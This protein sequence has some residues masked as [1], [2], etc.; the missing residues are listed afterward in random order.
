ENEQLAF[1]VSASHQE[2]EKVKAK[3]EVHIAELENQIQELENRPIET[4]HSE[5][6]KQEIERLT[7]QNEA[8]EEQCTE[9]EQKIYAYESQE[10]TQLEKSPEY[11]NL[12]K[13]MHNNSHEWAEKYDALQEKSWQEMNELKRTHQAELE[14]VR[15]ESMKAPNNS[16]ACLALAQSAHDAVS[17]LKRFLEAHPG[18]SLYSAMYFKTVIERLVDIEA[19][20]VEKGNVS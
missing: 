6:D 2:T 1:A 17:R 18:A 14:R 15:Q 5:E 20:Q 19:E 16:D 9:L 4:Y 7:V 10:Q 13:A 11:Q 12:M 8:L 3:F